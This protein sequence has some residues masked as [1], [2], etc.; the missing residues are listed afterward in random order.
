MD[1]GHPY[2]FQW[3]YRPQKSTQPFATTQVMDI[4]FV[5]GSSQ[6]CGHQRSFRF[7]GQATHINIVPGSNMAHRHQ[8]VA[9]TM[10]DISVTLCS[11]GSWT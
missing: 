9:Q 1:Y 4:S 8:E 11:V 2:A 7:Q 10:E 6:A 3:P 5:S